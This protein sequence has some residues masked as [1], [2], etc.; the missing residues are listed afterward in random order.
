M[1]LSHRSSPSHQPSLDQIELDESVQASSRY[2]SQLGL[3]GQ[4]SQE[5]S[6]MTPIH[7]DHLCDALS[8]LGYTVKC[9]FLNW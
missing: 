1:A 6:R 2:V 9:S 5:D 8:F 3:M 7:V 4:M